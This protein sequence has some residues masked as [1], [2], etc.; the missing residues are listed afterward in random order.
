MTGTVPVNEKLLTGTVSVNK[1]LLTGKVPV[2]NLIQKILGIF[3]PLNSH[4]E[5]LTPSVQGFKGRLLNHEHF[6]V[7]RDTYK[8]RNNYAK[9]KTFA[10]LSLAWEFQLYLK[11]INLASW[12]TKWLYNLRGTPTHR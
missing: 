5:L 1:E 8:K 7:Q 11:P 4:R 10:T 12:Y 9:Y 3:V 6:N 2:N